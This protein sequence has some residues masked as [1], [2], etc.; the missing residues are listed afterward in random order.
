MN[1]AQPYNVALSSR[2]VNLMRADVS[3]LWALQT[4]GV[5]SVKS[6][7]PVDFSAWGG[8]WVPCAGSFSPWGTH[9]GGEEYEP[10]ARLFEMATALY[11]NSSTSLQT[12]GGSFSE[13]VE[14]L[15]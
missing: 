2:L 13:I 9:L 15:T 12:L 3:L 7:T 11:G 1:R 8:V 5:L 4:T 14:H 10:D 6:S